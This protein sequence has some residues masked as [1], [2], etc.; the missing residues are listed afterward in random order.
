[1][2][3]KHMSDK[4]TNQKSEMTQFVIKTAMELVLRAK[5]LDENKLVGLFLKIIDDD[6]ARNSDK[7]RAAENIIQLMG[8][9]AKHNID[10]TSDGD[11]SELLSK[12]KKRLSEE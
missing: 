3:D 10:V 7:L 11:L 4:D 8:V 6:K 5:G 9:K 1:M 12:G 2:G